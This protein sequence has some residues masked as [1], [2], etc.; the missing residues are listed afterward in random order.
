MAAKVFLSYR[1]EDS[2][3]YAGRVQDR[4]AQ[5]FGRDLLFMDVDTVPLGVNFVT[6][7]HNEVAKCE[8]L[9]AVI[10]AHWLDA[11]D[12]AGNRRLDDPHD[13]VRIEIGAA[14]QR[15]IPV[16]PILL[17]GAKVPKATQLPKDLEE[18]SLR[19]GLDVRH[20]SFHNDIDKLV[21]SLKGQLGETDI[22]ERRSDEDED[23]RQKVEEK[24]R[25]EKRRKDEER[26]NLEKD[27]AWA[28]KKALAKSWPL[29]VVGAGAASLPIVLIAVLVTSRWHPDPGTWLSF[30][31]VP[32]FIG[33]PYT[34]YAFPY[35]LILCLLYALYGVVAGML[36][37]RFGIP[38]AVA[39]PVIPAFLLAFVFVSAFFNVTHTMN[40]MTFYDGAWWLPVIYELG[41]LANGGALVLFVIV[42]HLGL[43]VM[44]SWLA[45]WLW[46]RKY[47][48]TPATGDAA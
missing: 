10:G 30:A 48:V 23:R 12:D 33:P 16:I 22:S 19:N 1:R 40:L 3:G 45:F 18:L 36:I 37:P 39:I 21:R 28:A 43:A 26:R 38:I 9:L 17:D 6:I 4:L 41:N 25:S 2:A 42:I 15:N 44:C 5:E 31:A 29:P 13:F 7:L 24:R 27:A 20:A 11:R 32:M 35:F 46:D 8:V 34:A 47:Q 14:L